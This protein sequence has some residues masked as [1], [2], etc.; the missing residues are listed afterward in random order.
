MEI[1][2]HSPQSDHKSTSISGSMLSANNSSDS[3]REYQDET[4]LHKLRLMK[5]EQRGRIELIMGPMFAGK[6]TELLRRVNRLEISGKRCLS[7][8]FV[9][10]SRYSVDSISTHD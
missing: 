5:K 9:A 1:N 8:K 2:N 6:S 7:V 10:D 3:A 4:A